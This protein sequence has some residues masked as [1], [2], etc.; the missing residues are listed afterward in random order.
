MHLNHHQQQKGIKIL[1]KVK[2]LWQ[3]KFDADLAQKI[4]S[5][6]ELVDHFICPVT[7]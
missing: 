2:Y 6:L 3:G 1:I 5:C 7:L 4:I